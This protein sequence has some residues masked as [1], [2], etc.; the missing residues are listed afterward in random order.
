MYITIE[1]SLYPLQED[2]KSAIKG[3]IKALKSDASSEVSIRT[4]AMS[5]YVAG[6]YGEVMSSVTKHLQAVYQLIP[7]SA[8]VIKIIPQQLHVEDG[9]IDIV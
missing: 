9:F 4:T 2:Y 5:I 3:F 1:I 6:P 8:T 7:H